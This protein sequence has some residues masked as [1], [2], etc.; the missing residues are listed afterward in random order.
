MLT[1]RPTAPLSPPTSPR[2]SDTPGK[3]TDY[4]WQAS[5]YLTTTS[6]TSREEGAHGYERL[7]STQGHV[8][9]EARLRSHKDFSYSHDP[10]SNPKQSNESSH[11]QHLVGSG[12]QTAAT[13]DLQTAPY[14]GSAPN[15]PSGRLTP[16][17]GENTHN[18]EQM[19]DDIDE[20]DLGPADGDDGVDKT[21][22][23]PAELR[24]HKRKMKRFRLTHNQTRFLMS[25]FARQAHPDAAHR[26]RLSREIPGLSPRQVQVWFQNRRAKLK[27]LSTD[28]RHRM[29]SSRALP[30]NF[31]MTQ[32][33][34]SPFGAPTSNLGT[35]MP[36][37]SA[38]SHFGSD[39]NA[40]RPL[41]LDTLRRVPDYEHFNTQY[42]SP[43]G[44]N[45]GV[46]AYGFTPPQS[47]TET[48][49]PGSA[50]SEISP[51]GMHSRHPQESPRRP[52]YGFNA[53]HASSYYGSH[54]QV[55]RLHVH[56]RFS[57]PIS[58]SV[59][60]PLRTSMSYS[61][62]GSGSS[63][64]VQPSGRASSFS[65]NTSAPTERPQLRSLTNP[66]TS[67]SGPYG[68]GF[69]YGGQMPTY[70]NMDQSQQQS[71]MSPATSSPQVDAFQPY[72]RDSGQVG[73]IPPTSYPQ[74]QPSAFA[75]SQ[76]PQYAGY[77]QSYAQPPAFTSPYQPQQ[78]QNT[79]QTRQ[80]QGQ[81]HH[82]HAAY[83]PMHAQPQSYVS[84]D[85]QAHDDGDNSD[86]GVSVPP[87]Y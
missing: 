31:D 8:D 73:G 42:S 34:H 12:S 59:S 49:S 62:L 83:A 32:A 74:Y 23:T 30:D 27:R 87:S 14:G 35:P 84:N 70:Q 67:G 79:Q 55:S 37:P 18:D 54:A 46:G 86:G 10:T 40:I 38:F 13:E 43:S 82:T 78:A 45:T 15:S 5:S 44:M 20:D 4:D 58:E 3:A 48:I 57:R 76:I 41:T 17:S 28:D 80:P 1:E 66:V 33:L 25:E 68:L 22:M 6:Q 65:E 81:Q 51:F 77:A 2:M 21:K 52:P 7:T 72:R 60:S 56:D 24:A 50:V 63:S 16:Q 64:H 26:E 71:S 36:S 39:G 9:D 11:G 53:A 19:L 29:M 47:A 75:T 69:T 85:A 61:S